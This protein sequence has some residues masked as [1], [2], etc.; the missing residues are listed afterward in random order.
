MKKFL[1]IIS[2]V[3]GVTAASHGQ[4]TVIFA[5]SASVASHVSVSSSIGGT[6]FTPITGPAD[7]FYFALFASIN[8][9][10]VLGSTA[11]IIGGTGP[12]FSSDASFV[13]NDP[14]WSFISYGASTGVTGKFASSGAVNSDGTTTIPFATAASPVNV[15]TIGWSSNIGSTVASV[16]SFFNTPNA[17]GFTGE[18]AVNTVSAGSV[19][20]SGSSTANNVFSGITGLQLGQV[21][22]TPEP[23]SIALGVMGGLS[24]LALRRKKA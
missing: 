19:P 15:V 7:S 5:T 14:N 3:A 22:T 10:S 21:V 16:E 8:S 6:T 24:L 13:F 20:G 12:N 2:A 17:T 9:G 4:G 11:A 23:T 1:S 18:T